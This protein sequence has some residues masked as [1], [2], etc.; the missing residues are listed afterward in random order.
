MHSSSLQLFQPTQVPADPRHRVQGLHG[1]G[2]ARGGGVHAAAEWLLRQWKQEKLIDN[3]KD[4]WVEDY[5]L[6]QG[7]IADSLKPNAKPGW[8]VNGQGQTMI[9][10]PGPVEFHQNLEM[11]PGL[12]TG[13]H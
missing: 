11:R 13:Q 2:A 12:I 10:I 3:L 5:Q 4:K 9:L 8:F 7:V 1:A 6:R